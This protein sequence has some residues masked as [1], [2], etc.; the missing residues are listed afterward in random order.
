MIAIQKRGDAMNH[1]MR[2]ITGLLFALMLTLIFFIHA[3]DA[4]NVSIAEEL[5]NK[6]AQYNVT[7]KRHFF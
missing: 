2:K 1:Q 7:Q 3:A 6:L 4:Q 5:A